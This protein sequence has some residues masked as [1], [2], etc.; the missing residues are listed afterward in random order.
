MGIFNSKSKKPKMDMEAFCRAYY[1][2]QM[3][4]KIEK[5]ED[6]SQKKLDA[7]SRLLTDS[8]PHFIKVDRA[9]FEREMTAMHLELFALAFFQH[10]SNFEYSVQQSIFTLH[11]LQD[12]G[13]SDIWESMGKYNGFIAIASLADADSSMSAKLE[14]AKIEIVQEWKESHFSDPNNLTTKEKKIISCVDR[15]CNHVEVDIL[16]YDEIGLRYIQ[17][18]FIMRLDM[19]DIWEENYK[20]SKDFLLGIASQIYS[21]YKLATSALKTVDLRFP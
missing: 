1:D 8:D 21:M 13:R 19:K 9:L 5:G 12:K 6:N 7:A 20:A 16:Q 2:F 10:I 11:Y 3:F 15:V 14:E 17:S 18:C 4:H